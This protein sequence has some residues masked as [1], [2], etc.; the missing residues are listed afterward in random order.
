M[1]FTRTSGSDTVIYLSNLFYE[2]IEDV[3]LDP[4]FDKA[5]CVLHYDGKTLDTSTAEMTK[6]DF[7]KKTY[8]PYEFYILTVESAS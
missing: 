4:G 3:A 7:A 6:A 1:V 8:N 5:T 2:A